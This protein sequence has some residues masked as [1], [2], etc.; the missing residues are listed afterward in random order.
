[1]RGRVLESPERAEQVRVHDGARRFGTEV[2]DR[3]R[4]L[5]D[6]RGPAALTRLVLGRLPLG[7][8][9][10]RIVAVTNRG[11]RIIRTRRYVGC[12]KTPPRTVVE[13]GAG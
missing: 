11:D 13:R 2:G 7:T 1:V 4:R 9:T 3:C 5:R 8:Y 10:V 6:A 12:R